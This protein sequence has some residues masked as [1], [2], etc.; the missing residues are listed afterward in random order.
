MTWAQKRKK[1]A[2][3]AADGLGAGCSHYHSIGKPCARE[4]DQSSSLSSLVDLY[5]SLYGDWGE[6]VS[7]V[8]SLRKKRT[9]KKKLEKWEREFYRENKELCDLKKKYTKAEE[10]EQKR[11][12]ALLE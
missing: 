3:T 6:F 1:R 5:G 2:E 12:K 7:Q 9:Q 8:V 11:L 4:R 10:E